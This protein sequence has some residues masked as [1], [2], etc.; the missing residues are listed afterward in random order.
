MNKRFDET[1]KTLN[2]YQDQFSKQKRSLQQDHDTYVAIK[3]KTEKE[4][5]DQLDIQQE[6]EISVSDAFQAKIELG[7]DQKGRSST[8]SGKYESKPSR[9]Q[10][11]VAATQSVG[12]RMQNEI[13]S[14]KEEKKKL[15]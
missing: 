6:T 3:E 11:L 8:L 13:N 7:L 5:K 1:Q 9:A 10:Q 2:L 15:E 14:A 12:E 4:L